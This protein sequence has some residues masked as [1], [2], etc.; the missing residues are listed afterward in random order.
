MKKITPPKKKKLNVADLLAM[1]PE[2]RDPNICAGQARKLCASGDIRTILQLMDGM[3]GEKASLML[4]LSMQ[5]LIDAQQL[6]A[7][8]ELLH[9]IPKSA[10]SLTEFQIAMS[11]APK[12]AGAKSD[13]EWELL[14]S[15]LA[16]DPKSTIVYW[17]M[18]WLEDQ[19]DWPRA[20]DVVQ[21]SP[22]ENWHIPWL[23]FGIET[24]VEEGNM[25]KAKSVAN[26]LKTR[27]FQGWEYKI[28]YLIS[29]LNR[30]HRYADAV[31]LGSTCDHASVSPKFI[32]CLAW[33]LDALGRTSEALEL[34]ERY[35]QNK[36]DAPLRQKERWLRAKIEQEGPS[37]EDDFENRIADRH[38]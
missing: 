9:A 20:W 29:T 14:E 27:N 17:A 35:P 22:L 36:K 13:A 4:T 18:R 26:A 25:E 21:Q 8:W 12:V 6:D 38:P 34:C 10:W 15:T 7:A 3:K 30:Q 23:K 31:I 19:A 5:I 37:N 2:E 1:P 16:A 11:I 28:G 24:Y 32:S 33:A